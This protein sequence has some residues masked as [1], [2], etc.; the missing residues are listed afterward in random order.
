MRIKHDLV[1]WWIKRDFRLADNEALSRAAAE[2]RQV[3]PVYVFEPGVWTGEDASLLHFRAI[4]KAL[5]G[6][7]RQ[8]QTRGGELLILTG[9]LPEAFHSLRRE[10]PFEAVYSHEETGLAAT[11]RRDR[12]VRRELRR[13]GIPFTEVP[14]NGVVRGLR[15]RDERIGIWYGRMRREPLPAPR[16]LQVHAH[17]RAFAAETA[18]LKEEQLPTALTRRDR[19]PAASL[20]GDD[21]RPV[22]QQRVDEEAARITLES[23]LGIRARDY[24]AGIS[25]MNRAPGSCSRISVH[26]AWGTIS[27]RQVF[28]ALEK[29]LADPALPSGFSRGLR[30]FRSRIFWHDHFVQRLEDEPEAESQPLNRAFAAA[31]FRDDSKLLRAWMEGMT[32]FPMVDASMRCLQSSGYLNFRMRAML[33]SAAVHMLHL[34]WQRILYPMARGMADYVPGIHVSQTQMQA[35]VVGINTIRIYS[36]QKQLR[37]HD[38]DCRFVKKW[39]PELRDVP[40]EAIRAAEIPETGSAK[41]YPAPIVDY[42]SSVK[43]MRRELWGIKGSEFGREEAQRVL[44]RHGSRRRRGR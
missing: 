11:F 3:L 16:E 43:H 38:P 6:L 14:R 1:L 44:R 40:A 22:P 35:G 34:P 26:L 37:D 33:I 32:G 28:Q 41:A 8:I 18:L 13:A 23:F 21:G 27:M 31:P 12:Q 20:G 15:D 7:R 42:S 4:S 19:L 36:P 17:I 39:I 24:N 29:R 30:S 5:E 10:L 25:D 9:E 2:S